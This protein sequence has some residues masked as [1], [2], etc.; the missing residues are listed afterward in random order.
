MY[1]NYKAKNDKGNYTSGLVE[2]NSEKD[3]V[4]LLRKQGLYILNLHEERGKS[5]LPFSSLFNGVSF[6]DIVNFTRQY[7]TMI[8]SGLTLTNALTILIGQTNNKTLNSVLEDILQEIQAGNTLSKALEKYPK[9][10]CK[11]YILLIHVM[12]QFQ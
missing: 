7:S 2:A 8:S 5:N 11:I 6:N 12:F 1:F 9:Y 3:A 10:F 4:L